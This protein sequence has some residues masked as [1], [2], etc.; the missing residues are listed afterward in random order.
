MNTQKK[1]WMRLATAVVVMTTIACSCGSLSPLLQAPTSSLEVNNNSTPTL[2]T[3]SPWTR[4]ADGMVMVYVPEGNFTMGDATN[5]ALAEC[6]K[7]R[8]DCQRDWFTDEE[9]LHIVYLDAFWIDRTEVTNAMYAKCV[10]AGSCQPPSQSS[11]STRSSYY[12]NSQF[13]DYPVIYVSWNQ[14]NDYCTW[15]GARLPTETEWEKAARG[16]DGRIYP[17]GNAAPSCNLANFAPYV[18]SN[19]CTGDTQVVGSHPLGGSPY[20][21]LDMAGNVWEWVADWYGAT[22]YGQSPTSNPKGPDSGTKRVL[23]GGSWGNDESGIHSA[24]RNLNDPVS[25]NVSLGF[26][27]SRSSP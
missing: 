18:S 15:A 10:Q 27:C 8:N 25:S 23:R 26:R 19:A 9:P 12:G 13:D 24:F 4:P 21:A 7:F 1:M 14:A 6:Q 11:S 17:W 3:G 22:Y 16:T 2:G 20:G 5:Q